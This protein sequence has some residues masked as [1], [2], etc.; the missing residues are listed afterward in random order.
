MKNTTLLFLLLFTFA[1]GDK[2]DNSTTSTTT[3]PEMTEAEIAQLDQQALQLEADIKHLQQVSNGIQIQGRALTPEEVSLT[4]VIDQV[5]AQ[6]T[7][8]NTEWDTKTVTAE[9]RA[10]WKTGLDD[11]TEQVEEVM[12]LVEEQ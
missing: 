7:T 5:V 10:S 8:W 9:N 1:C 4:E 3:T 6:Y 12:E 11:L 2:P